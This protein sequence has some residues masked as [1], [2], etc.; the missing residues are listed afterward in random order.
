MITK[1]QVWKSHVGRQEKS[2]PNS[3]ISVAEEQISGC[4]SSRALIV[5]IDGVNRNPHVYQRRATEVTTPIK[6]VTANGAESK[7]SDISHKM[8]SAKCLDESNSTSCETHD[9]WQ[10]A[11]GFWRSALALFQSSNDQTQSSDQKPIKTL[12]MIMWGAPIFRTTFPNSW[13]MIVENY[14]TSRGIRI[15]AKL[16]LFHQASYLHCPYGL[17]SRSC[18]WKDRVPRCRL[19]KLESYL[20]S[21]W[22]RLRLLL[23]DENNN[24]IHWNMFLDPV[25]RLHVTKVDRQQQQHC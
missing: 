20:K 9:A 12:A 23:M 10:L 24:G 18:F 15:K 13:L 4:A 21:Q 19:S 7:I 3:W 2:R 8:M 16:Q 25:C 5:G 14:L 1:N 22:K 6:N 11:H 17:W